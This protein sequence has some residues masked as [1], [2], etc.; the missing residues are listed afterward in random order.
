M[1]K[2]SE[3][4]FNSRGYRGQIE[5][6]LIIGGIIIG[7]VVGGGLITLFWGVPALFTALMCFAG[8][9]VVVGIV[10]GFLKL[11]EIISRE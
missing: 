5:R 1:S 2:K 3:P 7:L 10:W 4:V 8:F 9:L 6:E 11:V